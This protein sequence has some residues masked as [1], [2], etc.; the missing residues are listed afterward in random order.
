MG[1]VRRNTTKPIH[2]HAKRT[3][4]K[5][6]I[7]LPEDALNGEMSRW[8]SNWEWAELKT[9]H[10]DQGLP[11][12]TDRTLGAF[13]AIAGRCPE[14]FDGKAWITPPPLKDPA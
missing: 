14:Y 1:Y 4:L 7:D 11:E 2:Q 12:P 5:N 6:S 13:I 3:N 10:E 9:I 8:L